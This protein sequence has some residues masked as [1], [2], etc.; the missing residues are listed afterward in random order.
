MSRRKPIST[1][2]RFHPAAFNPLEI[3]EPVSEAFTKAPKSRKLVRRETQIR[4]DDDAR[5]K[6]FSI[7]LYDIDFAIK[8]YIESTIKPAILENGRRVP[9]P[10]QYGSPEKWTSMQKLAALRDNRAK[11]NFPLIVYTRT[12]VSKNEELSKLNVIQ[13]QDKHMMDH[14]INRYTNINKYDRFSALKNRQPKRERYSMVVPTFVNI[15]YNIQIFCDFIEQVNQINEMFWDHH[16]RAWGIEYK[17]MTSQD[18]MDL[19]TSVPEN[20]DRITKSSFG[21]NVKAGLISENKDFEP[22]T[23]RNITNFNI[24]FGTRVVS[25]IDNLDEI[26]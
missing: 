15:S 4:R 8:Q 9:V 12:S 10:V 22:T 17:F 16:G 23:K 11:A 20:G 5:P 19:D 25:D 3:A 26:L 18:S 14:Y 1:L 24:R 2:H 6:S 7:T 21:L 13:S